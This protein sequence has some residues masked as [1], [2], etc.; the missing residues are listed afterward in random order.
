MGLTPTV[1][2]TVMRQSAKPSLSRKATWPMSP[3]GQDPRCSSRAHRVRFTPMPQRYRRDR[4]RLRL[5]RLSFQSG[6]ADRGGQDD[7]Q[8]HREAPRPYEQMRTGSARATRAYSLHS[9]RHDSRICRHTAGDA[10]HGCLSHRSRQLI[11]RPPP[12]AAIAGNEDCITTRRAS[13][14]SVYFAMRQLQFG[15]DQ[16]MY[17]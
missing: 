13:A 6:G 15:T 10:W 5:A 1:V 7:P 4:M 3:A 12:W 8:L 14:A 9:A 16:A 17:R 2:A 11:A